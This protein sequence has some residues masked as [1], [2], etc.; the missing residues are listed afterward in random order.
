MRAFES[1][2]KQVFRQLGSGLRP[3]FTNFMRKI[4]G[5]WCFF[6]AHV[7]EKTIKKRKSSDSVRLFRQA[8]RPSLRAFFCIG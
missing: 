8:E 3:G 5:L 2:E 1:V 4:G 7:L 6:D